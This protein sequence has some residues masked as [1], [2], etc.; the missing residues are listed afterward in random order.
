[1][2]VTTLL[3]ISQFTFI[4]SPVV[5][6]LSEGRWIII[7]ESV[8]WWLL[9][10][11]VVGL[12]CGRCVGDW[13][14][15]VVCSKGS[16]TPSASPLTLLDSWIVWFWFGFGCEFGSWIMTYW[17][18]RW[19][20]GIDKCGFSCFWVVVDCEEHSIIISGLFW[21]SFWPSISFACCISIWWRRMCSARWSER[22]KHFSQRWHLNG[23]EPVC[24]LKCRVNSS[25]LAKLQVQSGQVQM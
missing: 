7:L 25:D 14:V 17:C 19:A 4:A 6:W 10:I 2:P 11:N 3:A 21:P 12:L 15:G 8:L 16:W 23:F 18:D 22:E 24:F 9:L 1:M 5:D 20:N 13:G